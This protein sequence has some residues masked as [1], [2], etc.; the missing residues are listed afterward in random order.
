MIRMSFNIGNTGFVGEGLCLGEESLSCLGD[1]PPRGVA[2]EP[3]DL[4]L[5]VQGAQLA[6]DGEV[7]CGM[8]EA[9]R[10]PDV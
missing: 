1:K 8:P 2:C 3:H 4:D 7:T 10:V 5:W 9:D 6:S